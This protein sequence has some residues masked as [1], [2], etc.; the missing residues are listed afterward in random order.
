MARAASGS[1][2]S[3]LVS[4]G[5]AAGSAVAK[6]GPPAGV[7]PRGRR[8]GELSCI[9]MLIIPTP[10]HYDAA[11]PNRSPS[12]QLQRQLRIPYLS[13]LERAASRRLR[14]GSL[15]APPPFR[16]RLAIHTPFHLDGSDG[17]ATPLPSQQPC[18]EHVP[19]VPRLRSCRQ[20]AAAALQHGPTRT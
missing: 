4:R 6:T 1:Q 9:A 14:S 11:R 20:V 17:F 3:Q 8:P 18:S 7:G 12:R 15:F 2:S 19:T 5:G 10:G 13:T 16:A